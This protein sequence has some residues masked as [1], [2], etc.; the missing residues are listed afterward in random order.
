[1]FLVTLF[2]AALYGVLASSLERICRERAQSEAWHATFVMEEWIA[3]HCRTLELAGAWTS[4]PI[5]SLPSLKEYSRISLAV[6]NAAWV[7]ASTGG[8]LR[9]FENGKE[10]TRQVEPD[11]LN[12]WRAAFHVDGHDVSL[13]GPLPSLRLPGTFELA[14]VYSRGSGENAPALALGLPLSELE[15]L[16]RDLE[17]TS[18]VRGTFYLVMGE[19]AISVGSHGD[20]ALFDEEEARY[21]DLPMTQRISRLRDED[22]HLTVTRPLGATGWHCLVALPVYRDVQAMAYLR[23]ALILGWL[24]Q[25]G[26]AAFLFRQARKSGTY[27]ALSER[28]ALTGAGN[29]LGF[30]RAL[31][32]MEGSRKFPVCLIMMDVDGLKFINDS[33]GHEMGDSLLCRAARIL[34]HSLR[35]S[36]QVF[37]IGGDEFAVLIPETSHAMALP[38]MD[39]ITVNIAASR[40]KKSLPPVYASLGMA[41]AKGNEELAGLIKRADTAM[42]VN[43]NRTRQATR[44]ALQRWLRENPQQRDRRTKPSARQERGA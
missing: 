39:R 42:Y 28:D 12:A 23:L 5:P 22:G 16:L 36:D 24:F 35:D 2:F 14:A 19:A 4:R 13:A 30:E 33:L 27:K 44:E 15:G 20:T 6:P 29:R 25:C 21:A 18:S 31:E 38:L 7:V 41:E 9:L 40:E 1:M 11:V 3:G 26:F 43:K 17:K 8:E 34:H 32:E 37:R 10:R